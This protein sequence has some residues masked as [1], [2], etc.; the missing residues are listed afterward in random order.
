MIG[1]KKKSLRLRK[2]NVGVF[3][4]HLPKSAPRDTGD[5]GLQCGLLNW[6]QATF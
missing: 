1:V 6:K 2:L 4:G 5:R 3:F